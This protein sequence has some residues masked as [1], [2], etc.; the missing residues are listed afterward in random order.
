MIVT[1]IILNLTILIIFNFAIG[2]PLIVTRNLKNFILYFI[3]HFPI[4]IFTKI[5]DQ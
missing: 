1:S 3:F 5:I 2:F 4:W